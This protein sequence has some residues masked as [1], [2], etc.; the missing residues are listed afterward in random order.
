MLPKTETPDS[1]PQQELTNAYLASLAVATAI[2]L[3]LV[4]AGSYL[5]VDPFSFFHIQ[6]SGPLPWLYPWILGSVQTI[7]NGLTEFSGNALEPVQTRVLIQSL[8]SLLLVGIIVPTVTLLLLGKTLSPAA[9]AIRLV[10]LIVSL[11]LAITVI[12]TGYTAYRVRQTLREAQAVQRN[13][14]LIINDLNVIAW[15]IREYVI[16]P[17]ALGG[18]DGSV[19]GFVLPSDFVNTEEATYVFRYATTAQAPAVAILHASS[20]KC[21]G[22]EVNVTVGKRGELRDWVYTGQFE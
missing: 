9:R 12:P 6:S 18:G 7:V 2:V 5:M 19:A 22:A 17:K 21:A 14:D 1:G 20:K 3:L 10:C 15:K 4:F 8:A 11:T 13:K 16:V